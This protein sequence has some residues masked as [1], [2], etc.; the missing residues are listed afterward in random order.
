MEIKIHVSRIAVYVEKMDA[1]GIDV[2][3]LGDTFDISKVDAVCKAL[4]TEP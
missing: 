1:L 2:D 4:Q 3:M